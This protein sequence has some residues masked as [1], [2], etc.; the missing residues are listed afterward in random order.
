MNKKSQSRPVV[1]CIL[2][3]WGERKETE[4][5]AVALAKTPAW[6]RL[7]K[8]VAG[9][10]LQACAGQHVALVRVPSRWLP[11]FA[12]AGPAHMLAAQVRPRPGDGADR[13]GPGHHTAAGAAWLADVQVGHEHTHQG[14]VGRH[15]V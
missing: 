7:K 9:S 14:G 2:D 5:N 6:D 1:L 4:N 10:E 11:P 15:H 3:G 13:R 12:A 8:T